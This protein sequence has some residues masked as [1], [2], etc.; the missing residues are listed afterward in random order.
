MESATTESL[1]NAAR[2]QKTE[3]GGTSRRL[4]FPA[5]AGRVD[6]ELKAPTDEEEEDFENGS[7]E[8]M[9]PGS[10]SDSEEDSGA[11][12]GE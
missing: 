3:T 10:Y 9:S 1:G 6:N 2:L 11:E 5:D 8:G 7:P 12:Q 4:P